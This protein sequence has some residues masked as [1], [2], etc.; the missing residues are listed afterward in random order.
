M[1][2]EELIMNTKVTNV[3]GAGIIFFL[4]AIICQPLSAQNTDTLNVEPG[5]ETLNVAILG[6]TLP[7]GI[8]KN[9]NRVYR[10]ERG[11]FYLLNGELRSIKTNPLRIVAAKGEGPKPIL[12]PAVSETGAAGRVVRPSGNLVM[13][14]L[15]LTGIDNLGNFAEKN[16]MRLD[17]KNARIL[18]DDVF[19]DYDAQSFCRMNAEGQKY[20]ITN[21]VFRNSFDLASTGNGRILDTRGNTQD[22]IFVQN[23]T[24]YVTCTEP[25]R[26]G[27]GITKTV[28]LDHLTLYQTN[29]ELNLDRSIN[30]TITNNLFIDMNFEGRAI[31]DTLGD[32]V[33]YIDTLKA[34]T[35]ATEEQ[36]RITIKNN[37]HGFTPQVKAWITSV[38]SVV[39]YPLHDQRTMR[40]LATYP[41]MVSANNIE[42]YPVFSDPPD[43][44]VIVAFADYHAKTNFSEEGNPNIAA[45]RNGKAALVDD[46]LSAGPAPD[47]FDFDYSTTSLSYTHAEGGFPVG[48]LNWFPAKKA[49]WEAWV[50]TGVD[51]NHG[52]EVPEQFTLQQNYPN[53]FNPTTTIAYQL[54]SPAVVKVTIYNSL[55]QAIRTL[56]SDQ[57]QSAGKQSVQWNGRDDAGLAVAS[58][59][60]VYRVEA[61]KQV[62]SKKMLLMK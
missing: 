60:Y 18:I 6:D 15:Y 9:V 37:V 10:L 21:S 40:F 4:L 43:P 31:D 59:L 26:N 32:C 62:Q 30:L 11:G 35:L 24:W 49:A 14:G 5:Y 51:F 36:R 19:C 50:K 3:V 17:G 56:L 39:L 1:K 27:D 57:R 20:F 7:G 25:I 16:L 13:K 55:G 33:V 46:P 8:P 48:D 47:E 54:T 44:N 61:D 53:P 34:P 58:G 41:N 42:E 23:C 52:A 29:G 22:T 12:M 45:D 38:D 28:V 2:K